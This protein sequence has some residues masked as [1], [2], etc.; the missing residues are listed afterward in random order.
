MLVFFS[1]SGSEIAVFQTK[2][3]RI[4]IASGREPDIREKLIVVGW[5][6]MEFRTSFFTLVS[7]LQFQ[8]RYLR[9]VLIALVAWVGASKNLYASCGDYLH[10]DRSGNAGSHTDSHAG[11][12]AVDDQSQPI[13]H[14]KMPCHGPNC[15]RGSDPLQ[16]TAP[17]PPTRSISPS[18]VILTPTTSHVPGESKPFCFESPLLPCATTS[19]IFHPPRG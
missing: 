7:V 18:D 6:P 5:G 11:E 3:R 4:L 2:K 15:S 13:P 12:M 14:S 17:V 19:S 1:A 16:P 9:P 10:I 8:T